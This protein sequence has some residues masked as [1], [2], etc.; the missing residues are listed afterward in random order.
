M[1]KHKL[2]LVIIV[3]SFLIA[4]LIVGIHSEVFAQNLGLGDLNGYRGNQGT[5]DSFIDKVEMFLGL[6][7]IVGTI[8]SV[9]IL[10]VIGIKYM[11]SSVEERAEYK[12]EL[13]PYI[14]GCFILFS[15][16]WLPQII[17]D[18]MQAF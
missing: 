2:Y 4:M 1:K 7:S 16:S 18:I 15:G 9:V 12:K 5:A 8:L 14:I 3:I 6:I 17:Y 10:S 13:L 11:T